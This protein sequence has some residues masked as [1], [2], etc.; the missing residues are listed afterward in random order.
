MEKLGL[1]SILFGF[2]IV[3]LDISNY[4]TLKFGISSPINTWSSMSA[5]DEINIIPSAFY[6][7]VEVAFIVL[8]VWLICRSSKREAK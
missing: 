8:G 4:V 5:F 1:I 6:T 2:L 3:L 7:S